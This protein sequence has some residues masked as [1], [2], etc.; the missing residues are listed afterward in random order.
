MERLKDRQ[1]NQ[2][3]TGRA[4]PVRTQFPQPGQEQGRHG[5]P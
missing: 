2:E 3:A 5:Q 1:V 4:H